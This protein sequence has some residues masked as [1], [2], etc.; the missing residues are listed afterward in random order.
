MRVLGKPWSL[1]FALVK[2]AQGRLHEVR[3]FTESCPH[4]CS[5]IVQLLL[6]YPQ[7]RG[8]HPLLGQPSLTEDSSNS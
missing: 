7:W 5:V 2:S 3:K 6:A 1:A 8:A 4:L